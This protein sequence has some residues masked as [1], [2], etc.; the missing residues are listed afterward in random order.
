L[1]DPSENRVTSPRGGAFGSTH[2]SEA[3]FRI[4]SAIDC[5]ASAAIPQGSPGDHSTV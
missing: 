4:A 2:L 3:D 5:K 1:D